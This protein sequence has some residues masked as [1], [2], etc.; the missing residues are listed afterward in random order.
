MKEINFQSH[1]ITA[2][3]SAGGYGLKMANAYMAGIP[4]LM[5]KLP[6][7]SVTII[8]CKIIRVKEIKMGRS[9]AN[10]ITP[11][12][13]TILGDME[14]AG[15]VVGL[16]V[17]IEE[18]SNFKDKIIRVLRNYNIDKIH[19]GYN[20]ILKEF[21]QPWP[22]EKIIQQLQ[23]IKTTEEKLTGPWSNGDR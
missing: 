9:Y 10:Q 6:A 3:K 16:V 1:L 19:L 22:I 23:P 12:Q 11:I 17:L 5:I 20:P 4:D 7:Y 18:K 15:I 8:E 14:E 13:A 2:A 21:R